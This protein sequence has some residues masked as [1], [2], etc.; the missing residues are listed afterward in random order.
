MKPQALYL[1][2]RRH[3]IDHGLIVEPLLDRGKC[4]MENILQAA[5]LYSGTAASLA[6]LEQMRHVA[7]EILQAKINLEAHQLKRTEVTPCCQAADVRYMHTR[8][9]SPQT[10]LGD[11]HIPVRTF[12][13]CQHR[14]NVHPGT[15]R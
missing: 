8:M 15:P 6:I 10:L 14:C 1:F 12:Q 7:R 4:C 13:C 3:P 9:G 11:V 2:I 5:D